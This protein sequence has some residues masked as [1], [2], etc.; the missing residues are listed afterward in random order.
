MSVKTREQTVNIKETI[1]EKMEKRRLIEAGENW[2]YS[3]F[4]GP[5]ELTPDAA[6]KIAEWVRTEADDNW[7]YDERHEMIADLIDEVA[8]EAEALSE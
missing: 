8:D 5:E 2:E 1:L 3:L 7:G 6:R 4:D